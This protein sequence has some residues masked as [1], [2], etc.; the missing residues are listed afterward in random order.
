MGSAYTND[1]VTGTS[2][3]KPTIK[4]YKIHYK[5]DALGSAIGQLNKIIRETSYPKPTIKS[6]ILDYK[7]REPSTQV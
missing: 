2:Y 5:Y 7:Y 6:I 3:P 1:D 4:P